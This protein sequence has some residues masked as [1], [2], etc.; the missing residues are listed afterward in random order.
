VFLLPNLITSTGFMLGFWSITLSIRGEFEKA[1]LAIV[2]A[3]FCDMLDGRVARA[4]HSQSRFGFEFDSL[5]DLTAFGLAPALL[6]YNWTLLP[7]GP[8]G[9][10]IAGL[11]A[12][13]AALRLAR[14][15]ARGDEPGAKNFQGIASTFA[16]GM[17]AATV[18]F[19]GWLE[20]A[21]PFPRP[22]GLAITSFFALLALLMVSTIP[23]P[24]FKAIK[25]EGGRG[26]SALVALI[27]FLVVVLLNHEP[28]LFGLGILYVLS[29]PVVWWLERHKPKPVP[30]ALESEL[31][32]E[33]TG[34]VR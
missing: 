12:L 9:W 29:G 6:I 30:A 34:D 13:C 31:K 11:F 8:R 3:T 19:I 10:L 15:N 23:Y 33:S 26:Y 4:T 24:S 16:G 22:L 25:I 5:S 18:W 21:P 20:I 2:L 17:V 7:L 28:M 32:T 14:F 1:A 27:V